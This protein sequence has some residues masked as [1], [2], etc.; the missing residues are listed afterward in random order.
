MLTGA[1]IARGGGEQPIAPDY[2]D[3]AWTSCC[4]AWPRAEREPVKAK[5]Q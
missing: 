3:P 4:S 1:V 5:A 2:V